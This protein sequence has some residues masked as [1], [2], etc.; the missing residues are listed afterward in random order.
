[1]LGRVASSIL[2]PRPRP[3]SITP[4]AMISATESM[5]FVR[6]VIGS[7][8]RLRK[9]TCCDAIFSGNVSWQRML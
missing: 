4:I 7:V 1:M 2:V 6:S 8:S 9:V 3:I 5:V